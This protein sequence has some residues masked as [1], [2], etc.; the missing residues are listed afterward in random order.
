MAILTLPS[1]GHAKLCLG[2]LQILA[3]MARASAFP[4][5]AVLPSQ[6]AAAQCTVEDNSWTDYAIRYQTDCSYSVSGD[7]T[8]FDGIDLVGSSGVELTIGADYT[9]TGTM[10]D[11]IWIAEN[12][13]TVAITNYGNLVGVWAGVEL[14]NNAVTPTLYNSGTIAGNSYGIFAS[15]STVSITNEGTISGGVKAIY[16]GLNGNTLNIL[17]GA[18]FDGVV[19]YHETSGNTTT[20][21]S[22]SY[23]VPVAYYDSANNTII[24]DN[25]HQTL[26]M[27]DESTSSG[28]FEVVESAGTAPL[29]HAVTGYTGSINQVMTSVLGID[30]ER[31]FEGVDLPS[32]S[33]ALGYA[34][35]KKDTPA[36]AAIKKIADNTAVDK[37]G[38]LL[39][40]RAFGGQTYDNGNDTT[41]SNYG[42][43]AGIGHQFDFG[44]FGVLGGIGRMINRSNDGSGKVTGDTGFGGVYLRREM[45]GLTFDT[46]LIAGGIHSRSTREF[47]GS[48]DATGTFNGWYISPEVAVSKKIALGA[49]GW[50]V[51]PAAKLRY[52]AGFYRGYTETGS[53]QTSPMT[54]APRS[55]SRPC[56]KPS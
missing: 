9:V 29:P 19:D 12:T 18:V 34:E 37:F 7:I 55:L 30:I 6:A 46:S 33:G 22:G 47:S 45:A 40:L 3:L 50:S 39:W 27:T 28:T 26:A 24:L 5:Y 17:S 48:D 4:L 54:T 53:S 14:A 52:T 21:G 1:G 11:A 31:P 56:W 16:L 13:G 25:A 41:A 49:P 44:R 32:G 42:V 2:R 15:E 51:T 23:S 35:E 8:D 38:N 10:Y 43:A 20:F 36:T